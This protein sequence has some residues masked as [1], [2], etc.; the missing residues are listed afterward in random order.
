MARTLIDK[1]RVSTDATSAKTKVRSRETPELIVGLVGP[2][3]AGVT[4]ACEQIQK[5]ISDDYGYQPKYLKVS[6]IIE[7][8]KNLVGYEGE[9]PSEGDARISALQEIGSALRERFGSEFLTA[10]CTEA[11]GIERVQTG[12][13]SDDLS[14]PLA[15]RQVTVIDSLKNESEVEMLK[16]VYGSAFWL[17]GVFASEDIR[18]NRLKANGVSATEVQKIIEM[19]S[20]EGPEYGQD[21]RDT[22]LLSDYF[23]NNNTDKIEDLEKSC[24]RFL[25]V[26]FSES[27]L[28]PTEAEIG[29]AGARQV[30]AS[31]S[32]LSRQVGAVIYNSSGSIIG[33]GWNE[34]PKFGGGVYPNIEASLDNRCFKYKSGGC[35]NDEHKSKLFREIIDVARKNG[36]ENESSEKFEREVRKTR[37][38]SLIEFSRSVHA[39]MAAIIDVARN[40]TGSLSDA[41]LYVTTFPCHNC[42]R[43]IIFSGIRK[44]IYLEPYP[45][46]LALELHD[47]ALVD[48]TKTADPKN[49]S[50]ILE[51]FEG[52]GPNRFYSVFVR[53]DDIKV[54]GTGQQRDFDKKKAI[55][56]DAPNLDAFSTLE[57]RVMESLEDLEGENSDG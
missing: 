17:I 54:K 11:I 28:T 37:V 25:E 9:V 53:T 47:D 18:T 43:H 30:A 29:M 22:F 35:R 38:S 20:H 32:C 16:A 14:E 50:V 21:V 51:P 33:Q 7:A 49:N 12:Y 4:T 23:I 31:S 46:S 55:P 6:E 1:T 34:V 48:M 45:K 41:T 8:N 26:V 56:N 10:K 52:V 24:K 5:L 13:T 36:L 40:G 15:R 27:I 19:D 44:V 2:V 57:K 39:E 3:G 42:A